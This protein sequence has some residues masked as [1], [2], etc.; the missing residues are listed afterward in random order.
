MKC[1][2]KFF[3]SYFSDSSTNHSAHITDLI[4]ILTTNKARQSTLYCVNINFR[5]TITLRKGTTQQM[6]EVLNQLF[7]IV[8]ALAA[9]PVTS[10]GTCTRLRCGRSTDFRKRMEQDY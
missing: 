2:A 8:Y 10:L 1:H 4:A 7:Y 3:Y 6:L 5:N 9:K